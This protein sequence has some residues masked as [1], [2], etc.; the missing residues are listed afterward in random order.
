MICRQWRGLA[1]TDQARHYEEHLL[2]ETL[3]ALKRIDGFVDASILV[4]KLKTGVEFLVETRWASMDAIARFA[5][6]DV[7]AA[8]VPEDIQR[9]MVEYDR[10]VKHYE[11]VK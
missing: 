1:R 3:P 5:G 6:S 11:V 9:I 10:R 8:V 7:E 2:R 4:R